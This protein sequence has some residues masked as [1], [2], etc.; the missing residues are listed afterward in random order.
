MARVARGDREDPPGPPG[1]GLTVVDAHQLQRSEERAYVRVRR[2]A[3]LLVASGRLLLLILFVAGWA[4]ASDRIVDRLFVSTPLQVAQELWEITAN[5]QL[6][7]HVRFTLLEVLAGYAIGATLGVAFAWIVSLVRLLQ[8]VIHPF[9]VAFYGIPK[10]A[11]APL[12]IMW[13]GLGIT[14]KIVIAAIFVFF[15]VSM[16][17]LAG[18]HAVSRDLVNV[19]RVMGAGKVALMTKVVLPSALPYVLTALRI[20]IP[21]AMVGAIIGEFLAGNRGVGFLINS[22]SNQYNTARAFAGIAVLLVIVLA[23][24]WIVSMAERRLLRW[25]PAR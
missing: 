23:M 24:D 2:R 9:F 7:Y 4:W 17:T 8:Q 15:V 3:S 19:V 12:I 25:H 20:T 10:I 22:A 5:G 13:F 18:I 6:A 21:Q 16:N 11:L 14:P 1:I